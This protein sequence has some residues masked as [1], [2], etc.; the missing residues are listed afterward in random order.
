MK[1]FYLKSIIFL[2]ILFSF[3]KC[4]QS[5]EL[6]ITQ[7]DKD[8]ANAIE[9]YK[10]PGMSVSIVTADKVLL[11]KGYGVLSIENSRAVDENT[12]F[13]IAS[14][15]KTFTSALVANAVKSEKL[16][17]QSKIKDLYP[18]FKLYDSYVTNEITLAD[19]LSHRSGLTNFS[20]DLIWY[21][22]NVKDSL[23]ISR[24]RYLHPQ[25]GFRTHYGYSNI[26]YQLV[27]NILEKT[28]NR[29][30]EFLV[31]SI[32][33]A[34]LGMSRTI[35]K[36]E[37]AMTEANLAVP[38]LE[39][40]DELIIQPYLS[41]NNMNAAGGIFST[42]KD[43]ST[44]IQMWINKGISGD[45]H[46]ID[47]DLVKE[48]WKQKT[49]A[50]LSWV[51]TYL[52]SPVNFRSW[53][54]G[55]AMMDYDGYK[56]LHHSGG[57]DGMVCH[58]VIVPDKKLGAVF[59][60]NKTTAL[61]TVLMYH[62]LD[63]TI[64]KGDKNYIAAA[65][66]LMQKFKPH[67]TEHAKM[68]AA[69]DD[70]KPDFFVGDYYDSLIGKVEIRKAKNKY[71]LDWTESTIFK[72]ELFQTEMLTFELDWPLVPSLPRGKVIFDVDGTGQVKGF[73]I[74]LPNPDLHFDELYFSRINE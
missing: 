62:L 26:F 20:G 55:W 29:K 7:L 67:E 49:P 50:S 4:S 40:E 3:Q 25:Y 54:M 37:K 30:Y 69:P 46:I 53:G 24:L 32:I 72:G 70:L 74:E 39:K 27:G 59:L 58:M 23:I 65:Y 13:G 9:L 41:W 19:A 47:G 64:G 18:G 66:E 35:V 14:L 36:Y 73:K 48:I 10:V 15:T 71:Q 45:K 43:M 51:E 57:L 21:G 52:N 34:P 68:Y 2:L 28:Y 31:D 44:Y 17:Y 11:Q 56:V 63:Q 22:S 16:T 33:T 12:V 6:D 5:Q 61:P 1:H 8:F 60:T 42:A 38:H